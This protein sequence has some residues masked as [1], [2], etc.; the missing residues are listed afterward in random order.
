[1]F[2][3]L[4]KVQHDAANRPATLAVYVREGGRNG[5][6]SNKIVANTQPDE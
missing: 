1:M 2:F 3:F 6:K 4:C 5:I